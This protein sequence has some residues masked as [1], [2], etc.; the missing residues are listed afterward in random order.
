MINYR[1]EIEQLLACYTRC[2]DND[3]LEEWPNFFSDNAE[4]KIISREN[5]DDG[6]PIPVMSCNGRGMFIDRVV[7]HRKA[8]IFP[9]H[10]SCHIISPSRIVS[11]DNEIIRVET[12]YVVLQ[13]RNDGE[14]KIFNAGTY[15]DEISKEGDSFKFLKKHC[16]F[17][18]IR[19]ETLLV[20]PI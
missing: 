15:F 12:N 3:E 4:Y 20:T 18:T 19:I 1:N 6:Y 13:T 8:N 2:I 16:V 9:R 5:F 10:R 7:A 14:T 11:A 17:D